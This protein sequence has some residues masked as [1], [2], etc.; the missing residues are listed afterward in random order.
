MF[1]SSALG[2]THP[3][4]DIKGLA[5]SG[6]SPRKVW[7][8]HYTNADVGQPRLM[9]TGPSEF[10]DRPSD[11][12]R[13]NSA[14]SP[15]RD[16]RVVPVWRIL[17]PVIALGIF[18]AAGWAFLGS[19]PELSGVVDWVVHSVEN[20]TRSAKQEID[21]NLQGDKR[22]R[23]QTTSAMPTTDWSQTLLQAREAHAAGRLSEAEAQFLNARFQAEK[24]QVGRES[25]GIVLDNTAYF[26]ERQGRRQEAIALYLEALDHYR[27]SVGNV[28]E[29]VIGAERRVA[30][31]YRDQGAFDDALVHLQ[32][33]IDAARELHGDSYV[34]IA[35]GY[36]EKGDI[37]RRAG[38]KHGARADYERAQAVAAKTLEP[39]SKLLVQL[40]KG[41]AELDAG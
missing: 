34:G 3:K 13:V 11:F 7:E 31:A 12:G 17:R 6:N 24:A 40:R 10:P 33:A 37:R 36:K 21:R 4:R 30:Y 27:A 35:W 23:P 18:A 26:Y 9:A 14:L 20:A 29:H 38:D 2:D 19:V 8:L 41:L 5:S 16:R 28:H 39:Q 22:K 32:A 1:P 25:M 15:T